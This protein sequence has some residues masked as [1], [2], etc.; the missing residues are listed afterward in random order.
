[1]LLLYFSGNL[2]RD[3]P[4][5][6]SYYWLYYEIRQRWLV[7]LLEPL[8]YRAPRFRVF[9]CMAGSL[10]LDR[11]I[12]LDPSIQ[13]QKTSSYSYSCAFWTSA[14]PQLE[15]V[16][17]VLHLPPHCSIIRWDP[18]PRRN[19]W[20]HHWLVIQKHTLDFLTVIAVFIVDMLR[21]LS[22]RIHCCRK[23]RLKKWYR[24]DYDLM[25]Q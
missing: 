14:R 6:R 1:M 13:L 20:I 25:T 16:I 21:E 7:W 23:L 19:Q 3:S 4:G 8:T 24:Y 9:D 5:G 18:T 12:R 17:L 15:L 22:Q 2:D 11:H 10:S